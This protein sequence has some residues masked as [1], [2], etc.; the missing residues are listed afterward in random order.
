MD[1]CFAAKSIKAFMQSFLVKI[2]E[3][4]PDEVLNVVKPSYTGFKNLKLAQEESTNCQLLTM[5]DRSGTW[6]QDP[7]VTVGRD[8]N[9]WP[10]NT[11]F[12]AVDK[13]LGPT[14]TSALMPEAL[15]HKAKDTE[16]EDFLAAPPLIQQG[17]VQLNR[18]FSAQSINVPANCQHHVLDTQLRSILSDNA[19]VR[20]LAFLGEECA[21][22]ILEDISNESLALPQALKDLVTTLRE[23]FIFCGSSSWRVKFFASA[24]LAANR[25]SLRKIVLD[26][27][28]GSDDSKDLM[29][30][31]KF[32]SPFLFGPVSEALDKLVQPTCVNYKENLIL[33]PAQ[34][35]QKSEVSSK[36]GTSKSG[37]NFGASGYRRLNLNYSSGNPNKRAKLDGK[38]QQQV[39]QPQAR[40]AANSKK[41][42]SG[43]SKPKG[44]HRK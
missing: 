3:T 38:F 27:C 35:S 9:A 4:W 6:L 10:K 14:G 18:A 13:N 22:N 24:A 31:S 25:L 36:P 32:F 44:Q 26:K 33:V 2:H 1:N 16:T 28:N 17:K 5:L 7:E 37:F 43:S 23:C 42:K 40:K 15:P 34:A 19:V 41:G 20:T 8:P 11:K 30:N 21:S 29:L 39:W 12:P